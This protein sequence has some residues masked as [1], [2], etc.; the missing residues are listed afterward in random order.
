MQIA[1]SSAVFVDSNVNCHKHF[2]EITWKLHHESRAISVVQQNPLEYGAQDRS[3]Q[4]INHKLMIFYLYHHVIL[5][6]LML[7]FVSLF[8]FH[9]QKAL[10][11]CRFAPSSRGKQRLINDLFRSFLPRTQSLVM[12]PDN[13]KYTRPLSIL[14]NCE[15]R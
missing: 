2:D 9:P 11:A 8:F 14:A 7:C 10:P 1:D 5:F 4:I 15:L 3:K 12:R 6:A 13:L